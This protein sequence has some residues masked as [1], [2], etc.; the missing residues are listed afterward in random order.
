MKELVIIGYEAGA[1]L[2]P[3]SVFT[4]TEDDKPVSCIETRFVP[5]YGDPGTTPTHR[6]E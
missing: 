6:K 4:A 3:I 1:V 2:L 5:I